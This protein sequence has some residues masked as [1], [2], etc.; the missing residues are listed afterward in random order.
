MISSFISVI[1]DVSLADLF[2]ISEVQGEVTKHVI[3]IHGLGGDP[4]KTWQSSSEPQAC[5]PQWLT[6]DIEG[7]AVWTVGY[8]AAV[9]LWRGSAM[10]LTDRAT[11]V[12]E[13]ILLEPKLKA[14]EIVLIGHSLGGLIIKQLLRTAESMSYQRS[15]A[16]EFVKRV[17]RVAFL[18]TPHSGSDLATWGD[19]LRIIL[20]P[21]AATACLVRNDP[22]L[23]D[24]NLWYREWSGKHSVAH[25]I[26]IE[27]QSIRIG[28]LV[29]KP[30][31]SD[32]GLSSR[33]ISID[34]NHFTICKPK[35]RSSEI[36]MHIQSFIE[37]RLE[38][39][40]REKVIEEA[41]KAQQAQLEKLSDSVISS[42]R[43]YPEELVNK[44]IQK[45]LSIM[46][47]A[48]FFREF[49][50]S[51]HA[52]KLAGKI[53]SGEFEGGSDDVKSNALAWSA[54]FLAVGENSAK[55]DE[56]LNLARQLGNGPEIKVAEAFRI[57]ANGDLDGAL[58][59]LAGEA[60]PNARSA[61]F[62]IV[63]NN[64]DAAFPIEWLSK[65]GIAHSDLDA[66]GKFFLIT[67]LLDLSRWD[68]AFEHANTLSEEEYQEA[69]A[70]LHAAAMAH[71]VQA[72][73]DEIKSIVLHQIPFEAHSFPLASNQ[74]SMQSRRKAQE[75]FSKCA[76]VAQEFGCIGAANTADDYALWLELRDPEGLS[77]GLEKLRSSMR[78]SAHS[79]RRLPFA[80]AFGLKL[81]LDAVEREIEQRSALSGG[82]SPDAA[83]ARF[84]LALTQ[85]NPKAV[86]DYI[87]CHRDQIQRYIEKKAVNFIEIEMLAKAGLIQRAEERLMTLVNDGL[88]EEEQNYLRRVITESTGTDPIETSKAQ[89]ERSGQIKDLVNLVGLLEEKSDWSQ[90]CHFGSL[91]FERTRS[92][93]DAERLA[94][95]LNEEDNYNDLAAL[96]K[97]YPEFLDQSDTLQMLWSWSLY[98][99]G[100]FV[101]SASALEKLSAKRDHPNDRA[102]KEY[103][104]ISSGNW[105]ALLPYVEEE[106]ANREKREVDDLIRT[107]Q[108]AHFAGSP[109]AKELVYAAATK[110]ANNAGILVAAYSLA[111]SAGWEDE[112]TVAQW[113][114]SAAELS[115][116]SG[117][118]QKMSMKDILDRA[119]EWNRRESE[120]WQNLNE[121]NLPIFVAARF[122]NR[123]LVDMFLLP[124]LANPSEQDPRRRV[125][126]PAYSGVRLSLTCTYRVVAIE[127]AAL[128][129]LG[130]LGLLE[131][132]SDAFE[133]IAIPHSTLRWLFEEKQKVSFHQPSRIREASKLRQL[134]ATG[135]L[136][137]FTG[138]AAIDTDLAAEVGEELASLIAEA[139]TGSSVDD[140][141][142]LVIRSSPVHC[143]GS[144]MEEEADL[145]P[146]YSHLCSCL[147]VVN[148]LK[149]KGQLTAIEESH[150]RSYLS[151]H[152]K[153]WPQQP[154]ISD[155]AVLYLDDLSVTYLQ[156]T[157]LL[158][159]L[160]P[161]G[162]EVYVSARKIEEINA[163]LRHE[164]LASEVGRVI[165]AIRSFLTVG[166]QTGKVKVGK[167]PSRD[168]TVEQ[169]W[170]H[171]PTSAIIALAKN[172]EA[173]FVDDRFCNQHQNVEN[174]SAHTPILTTL[175][176]IDA[177]HSRDK[178]TLEQLFDYR[179]RLRRASYLFIPP[180]KEE[181]E[182]HLSRA[183][184]VNGRFVETAE[185]KAVRENIL[186]IRMSN[187]L[188]LP[189]EAH[190]LHGLMQTLSHTLRA[191][192]RPEIDEAT[193]GIRSEWLLKLLNLRGWAHCL[194]NDGSFYIGEHVYGSQVLSLLLAPS[195][196]IEK[197]K[198]YWEWIEEHV[199]VDI[200]EENPELY[201]WII[202]GAQELIASAVA[203]DDSKENE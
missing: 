6:E 41:L 47:R 105:E 140:R 68:T 81:D 203:M 93:S 192:W 19:R 118:V 95:A 86:A 14:G 90:L 107:A 163:L 22:N 66:V 175:D 53:Q 28:V 176:L 125:L 156:H 16:A 112:T 161:A 151:L 20:Q 196:T 103:L 85:K 89:F 108:L 126:V 170:L 141:Q 61:A 149:Q 194:R 75:L 48:R 117:P 55:S 36:Y 59:K 99:E 104:A 73:P 177:L 10:H 17:R 124:A 191:Q 145:S 15:D 120:T 1:G 134:L 181:L 136:K 102:L 57:S 169:T 29:V 201:S 182:H 94:R 56:L 71:L 101:E 34:A 98:R 30:D 74:N 115:D 44:E 88:S 128:L 116:D 77:S 111:T 173:L 45:H 12:L 11:N 40:H 113:L 106:W 35:D 146:Y 49:S 155:R 72:I 180:T 70:L 82:S 171:H 43:K 67:K 8:E 185:L 100:L 160:Q 84:S 150:A 92:L 9:S 157:G 27:N 178:I 25:L 183:S 13:R 87:D 137:D 121:G 79:L 172:V 189:K 80:L 193:A 127:A 200:R 122:L 96:I 179:T 4:Y 7:V 147:A 32:P 123:S 138:S 165:E 187:F 51:D 33:P 162:L 37:H 164:Q 110:G 132:A 60:T 166:I 199:L 119:P 31:S 97:K 83:L 21:S 148:K 91:L 2:S 159:K 109:R 18:A 198:K 50:V 153:D 42:A 26:L 158:E 190:F 184:I 130:A 133:T 129:T 24:L 195:T 52:I 174:G 5:W 144:L 78:E 23:R 62:I 168:R 54:R 58:S 142:R 135:V 139:Q 38:T 188:Q 65:S 197:K 69:P 3:F 131:K 152:E 64:K 114:H 63:S 154:E 186:R 76:S 143:I 46:Q 39:G 167:M 202:K